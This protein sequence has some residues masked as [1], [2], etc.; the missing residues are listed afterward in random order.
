MSKI[1]YLS[2]EERERTLAAM[3][4]SE[5]RLSIS[6]YVGKLITRDADES[7]LSKYFDAERSREEVGH[8]S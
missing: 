1:T 7:G 4:A 5:L 3:R 8:D 2:L 6:Q